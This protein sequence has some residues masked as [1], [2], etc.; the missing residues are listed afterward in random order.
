MTP[1]SGAQQPA[2]EFPTPGVLRVLSFNAHQGISGRARRQLLTRMRSALRASDADLVFLQE[3]GGDVTDSQGQQYEHLADQTWPQ[4]AYGRNAVLAGAHQGNALL[5]RYPIATWRNV[6]ISEPTAEPRGLLRCVIAIP[7]WTSVHAIC[8]HLGLRER[9]RGRQ[10]AALLTLIE[11]D[12]ADGPLV[13]AGDFNDWSGKLHRRLVASGLQEVHAAA[14]GE[15][16]RTFPAR[17]PVL[18][19]DRIY[20]RGLQH[21]PMPLVPSDWRGLSDHLAVG[22]L[23]Y[24]ILHAARG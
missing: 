14:H 5:S 13:L 23:L 3:I 7:G 11:S 9:Q 1:E 17:W 8:V 2:S 16:A 15:P 4:F 21:R 20:V 12:C 6:D 22:A 10:L 18:R 24:R 19:L